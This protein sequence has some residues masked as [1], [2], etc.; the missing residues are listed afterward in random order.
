MFYTK[1]TCLA[2]H[3]IS[4][5]TCFTGSQ[6]VWQVTRITFYTWSTCLASHQKSL[7]TCFTL[8]Q[9][10]WKVTRILCL[11]VSHKSTCPAS[12]QNSLFTHFI[13]SQP[14]L[15][16]CP[17]YMCLVH[18]QWCQRVMQVG[19]HLSLSLTDTAII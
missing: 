1:S 6:P 10:V 17:L 3:Q 15:E 14:V 13:L 7:L 2:C 16:F 12:H 11:Y 18:N 9:P 8:S 5:F 19:D 4:L